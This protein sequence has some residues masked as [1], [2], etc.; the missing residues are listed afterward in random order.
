MLVLIL[1]IIF[2]ILLSI[3]LIYPVLHII[4]I[5]DIPYYT[6]TLYDSLVWFVVCTIVVLIIIDIIVII[7]EIE[8]LRL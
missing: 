1:G 6:L 7:D 8:W 3:G 4:S 5:L 2:L